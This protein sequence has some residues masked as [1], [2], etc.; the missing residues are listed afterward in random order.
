[1]MRKATRRGQALVEFALIGPLVILMVAGIVTLGTGVFYQQQLTNAAREAARYAAIHSETSQCPTISNL[2][3]HLSM[4]PPDTVDN[5]CDPPH[6]RWPEMTSHARSQVWGINR[7][8]VHVAACWSG[9]WDNDTGGYDAA[10]A[11]PPPDG[12]PNEFRT[13]T[14][15]GRDPATETSQISC[16]PPL[17][18]A[19]DDTASSLAHSSISTANQVTVYACYNWSPPFGGLGFPVPC[20]S[21]WCTAEII[22]SVTTLRA[23]ITE[24]M[25]HQQ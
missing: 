21:G 14:I 2:D 13:C 11:K 3:P 9:Y 8:D 19:T 17:T 22:P 5:D 15:G 23:V 12:T 25:Q 18:T 20:E 7:P 24:A 10:P 6:L 1:M 4:L 16:P